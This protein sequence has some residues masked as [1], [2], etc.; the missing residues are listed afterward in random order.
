MAEQSSIL[1]TYPDYECVIGIE[2]HVQLN[3]KSKIFCSCSNEQSTEQNKNICQICAG[4]PGVLPVLNKQVVHNAIM[5]G[6]PPIAPFL[7]FQ[8]LLENIIFILI[9]QKITKLRKVIDQ[10]VL[11]AI[12]P[13]ALKMAAIKNIR[14][15]RIHMEEDAG[16]NIHAPTTNESFVDLNRTGTPLL[17]I[18][19]HPDIANATEAKAYLKALR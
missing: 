7:L 4:Y 17:E 1:N 18:V 6:L 9:Y 15:I 5:A 13:L 14:L 3:T 11:M 19:S 16:K 10:F 12:F 8:N 2:V